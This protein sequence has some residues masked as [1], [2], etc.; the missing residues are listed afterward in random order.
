MSGSPDVSLTLM[1]LPVWLAVSGWRC[2]ALWTPSLVSLDLFPGGVRLSGCLFYLHV[3][4]SLAGGVWRCPALWTPSLVSLDLFPGG[5]R[6]S[7]CLFYLHV[8]PLNRLRLWLVVSSCPDIFQFIGFPSSLHFAP[9]SAAS[10]SPDVSPVH[11]SPAFRMSLFT[12]L[13][14]SPC[15]ALWVTVFICLPIRLPPMSDWWCPR[16]SVFTCF[17]SFVCQPG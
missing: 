17:L 5:V 7:G 12:C 11:L 13:H 14:L 4:P 9:V 8:S 3:S 2:P 1:C 10:C 15:P 6:L 16:M